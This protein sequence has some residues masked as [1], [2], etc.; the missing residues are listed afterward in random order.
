MRLSIT[1]NGDCSYMRILEKT[2]IKHLRGQRIKNTGDSIQKMIIPAIIAKTQKELDQAIQKVMGLTPRLQLDVMDGCFVP[3]RSL[4]FDF[5]L[6]KKEI[7]EAHLMVTNPL[8]WV[9]N[10]GHKVDLILVHIESCEK[11]QEIINQLEEKKKIGFALNPETPLEKIIPLIEYIDQVLVMTVNPGFYGSPFIPEALHK[12]Q[13]LRRLM[14][15]LDIEVDGNINN[16]TISQAHE[17]GANL[18]VSG[19]YI[20]KAKN[21]RARI[22]RLLTLIQ[23]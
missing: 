12:V 23:K 10:H 20:M 11:P 15:H 19:S 5:Q 21:T 13:K 2:L 6:P 16:K 9:Q 4:D 17:M 3:N 7:Y 22:E 14:P 18:F 1:T 8:E